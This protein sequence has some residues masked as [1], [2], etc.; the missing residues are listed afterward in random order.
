[1]AVPN[2]RDLILRIDA[3]SPGTMPMARLAEYMADL[4][5]LLG[6]KS[7]VH[8]V[9]L[10][11]GSTQIVHRVD[12]EALPKVR[13]RLRLVKTG[14]GPSEAQRA[15]GEIDNRLATD[16]ASGAL[17]ESTGAEIIPFAG[18]KRFIEPEFGPFNEPGSLDGV[19][20]RVG[21]RRKMVPIHL[22]TREGFEP[23]CYTTRDVAKD[24]AK[25][26]FGPELRCSGVGR[27][28]RDKTG[29]WEMRN[30]TI[31]NFAVLDARPL[32]EV[33][34]DLQA[35]EESGWRKVADPWAELADLRSD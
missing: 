33:V 11:K 18:V 23:N 16:N 29:Q 5:T 30:F 2:N 25:Y 10:R 34:A 9:R 21:G 8:F 12:R 26:I 4:A 20:V 35:V 24:M 13:E 17:T 31:F 1:M 3:Y 28:Y 15:A 14:T 7:N 32:P 27:W 22:Q 6:E 19:V